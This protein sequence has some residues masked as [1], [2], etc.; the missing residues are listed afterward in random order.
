M[1]N[2]SRFI[3]EPL[4]SA[5]ANQAIQAPGA[6]GIGAMI[7]QTIQL[8]TMAGQLPQQPFGGDKA[9]KSGALI[10]GQGA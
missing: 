6:P 4:Q 3:R 1:V 2:F 9:E 8:I 5:K 7:V 10:A